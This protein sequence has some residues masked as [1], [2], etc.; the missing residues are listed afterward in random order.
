MS[1]TSNCKCECDKSCDVGE[2]LDYA[3][4]QCRKRLIDKLVTECNEDINKNEMIYNG[5]LN[6][7]G[8]KCNSSTIYMVLLVIAFLIIIDVS[9]AYFSFYPQLKK[10]NTIINTSVNTETLIYQTYNWKYQ[11][12]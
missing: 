1:N 10:G 6:Y 7:Y 8:E 3:N 12:N 9:C 5:N 4:C 11:R 2:Y